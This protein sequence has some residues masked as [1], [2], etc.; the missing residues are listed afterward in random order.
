MRIV[1]FL[2][3]YYEVEDVPFAWIRRIV[4]PHNMTTVKLAVS[5]AFATGAIP[6]V[7]LTFATGGHINIAHMG[8]GLNARFSCHWKCLTAL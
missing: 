2:V 1:I 5:L 6:A 8:V 4:K 3:A 7:S